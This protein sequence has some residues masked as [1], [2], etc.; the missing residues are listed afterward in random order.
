MLVYIIYLFFSAAIVDKVCKYLSCKAIGL[1]LI[2]SA[3]FFKANEALCSPSAAITLAL[4][5]LDASASV[6]TILLY[7]E[8]IN[9]Y[10]IK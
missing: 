6:A 9:K 10:I 3:A 5:S 4:A 1:L 2:V 7:S 8:Q